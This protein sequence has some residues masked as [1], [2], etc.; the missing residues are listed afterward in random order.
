MPI[1]PACASSTPASPTCRVPAEAVAAAVAAAVPPSGP[2]ALLPGHRDGGAP[3]GPAGPGAGLRCRGRARKPTWPSS[4]PGRRGGARRPSPSA[5]AAVG[6]AG[7][8]RP[9]RLGGAVRPGGPARARQRAGLP[10]SLRGLRVPAAAGHARPG[11]PWSRHG[12]ARCPKCSA[13]APCWSTSG[14]HDGLAEALDACLGDEA[15]RR[16]LIAA[17]AAW[18]AA[19]LVGALRRRA[20]SPLSRRGGRPRG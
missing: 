17:G 20:R 2:R 9:H 16:R 14:D 12:R 11:C 15:E 10:L 1:R 8:D 4:S 13:T 5:I 18:S 19:L 6:G 7:Q 3:E